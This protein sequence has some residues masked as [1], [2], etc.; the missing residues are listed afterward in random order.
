MLFKRKFFLDLEAEDGKTPAPPA[1][2]APIA[3]KPAAAIQPPVAAPTAQASAEAPAAPEVQPAVAAAAT[4]AAA[5]QTPSRTTAEAIAA[6]LAAE[7]ANRP[8]PTQATFAP[9]FLTPGASP[10]RRRKAGA[11]LGRFRQMAGGMLRS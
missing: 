10:L 3:V 8:A 2:V 7:Q 6:E 11:D 4:P 9:E 1:V 5:P